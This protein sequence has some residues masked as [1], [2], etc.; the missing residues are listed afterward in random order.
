MTPAEPVESNTYGSN[1]R[2]T[3]TETKK[4]TEPRSNHVRPESHDTSTNIPDLL[5]VGKEQP[6]VTPRDTKHPSEN[7]V[8]PCETGV[9]TL[10]EGIA[11]VDLLKE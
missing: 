7:D 1:P 9:A 4:L 11:K 3:P 5:K 8:S 10:K 6:G 2:H